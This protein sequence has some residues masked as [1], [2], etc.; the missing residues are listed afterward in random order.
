MSLQTDW[1]PF[2]IIT[3]SSLHVGA[4]HDLFMKIKKQKRIAVSCPDVM[5]NIDKLEVEDG[6]YLDFAMK[7]DIKKIVEP[8]GRVRW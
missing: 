2:F 6:D 1:N 4:F 8:D 3:Y 5:F 7:H